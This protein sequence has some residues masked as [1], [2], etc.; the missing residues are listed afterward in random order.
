VIDLVVNPAARMYRE[1]NGLLGDVR[2]A[3]RGRAEL[4]VTESLEELADVAARIARRGTDL[5]LVS[6][7]DGTLMAAASALRRVY[8][9][10]PLPP[11]APLPG[12]TAGTVARNWG[13]Q[14]DPAATLGKVL[15][16]PRRV[17]VRASLSIVSHEAQGEVRRVG[18][19][20]GTGLV[21][22]FFRLYY[23]RGAPG[24]AGSAQLVARIFAE[25]FW[26]GPLARRV[27]DP[28][29]CKLTVDGVEQPPDAWSLLCCAVVPNLGIHMLVTYRGG[30][31]PE[32]PH[33]VATPMPP[34]SLGPRLPLVLSGRRLGGPHHVDDL[35]KGFA[36]AFPDDTGPF[37]LDGELLGASRVEV[38]A[39]P[40][41]RI[42]TAP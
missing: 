28:L 36:V 11:L 37:V 10:E 31:D 6:G 23:E 41:L 19:I 42:V 39:G 21:A 20:F 18:F 29:P 25:S 17:T 22:S 5:L 15:A 16:G 40:L 13:V 12:G 9:A 14:G 3:A 4:H 26:G 38:S 27:L 8:D 32:R 7:G 33:L 34:R 24:Y 35:V 1:R 30:E 2:E